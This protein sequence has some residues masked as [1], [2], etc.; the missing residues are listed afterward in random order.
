MF[1]SVLFQR[2][3]ARRRQSTRTRTHA[4]PTRW[5]PRQLRE[6]LRDVANSV[7][8][9]MTCV[10][11]CRPKRGSYG[12]NIY[13]LDAGGPVLHARRR[14][15]TK[16]A[17]KSA[18]TPSLTIVSAFFFFPKRFAPRLCILPLRRS[19]VDR[20]VAAVSSVCRRRLLPFGVVVVREAR[21]IRIEVQFAFVYTRSWL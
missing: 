8:R 2:R 6:P 18:P 15:D 14:S 9:A 13:R 12:G 1:H 21:K 10:A 20:V 7:S 17:R 11:G 3:K 19:D 16:D 4:E 5:V